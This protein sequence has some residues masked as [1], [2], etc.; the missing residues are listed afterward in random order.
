MAFNILCILL[1]ADNKKLTNYVLTVIR[2]LFS[3]SV[4]C[5]AVQSDV[6]S[7]G[8]FCISYVKA[9]SVTWQFYYMYP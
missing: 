9:V 3:L 8:E 6:V 5:V 2:K 1:N 4:H 7:V